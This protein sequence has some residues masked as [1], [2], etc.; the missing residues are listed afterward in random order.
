MFIAASQHQSRFSHPGIDALQQHKKVRELIP[1]H[2][3]DHDT[4]GS[5][6]RRA[7]L[8]AVAVSPVLPFPRLSSAGNGFAPTA[9]AA[10][11][12]PPLAWELLFASVELVD[13][14]LF[15]VRSGA[16]EWAGGPT[17]RG[18]AGRGETGGGEDFLV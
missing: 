16:R 10:P 7:V 12:P 17:P 1:H 3:M 6:T 5:D 14:R 2:A 8:D 4:A 11:P 9:A 18:S 13:P 15:L